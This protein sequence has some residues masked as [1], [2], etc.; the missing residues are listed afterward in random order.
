MIMIDEMLREWAR[1]PTS[2]FPKPLLVTSN[3]WFTLKHESLLTISAHCAVGRWFWWR[4]YIRTIERKTK[5]ECRKI[6]L[7]LI[8]FESSGQNI[9]AAE[10][11]TK[12]AWHSVIL[13]PSLML[14]LQHLGTRSK[15]RRKGPRLWWLLSLS[16]SL[17]AQTVALEKRIT[18][19]KCRRRHR[20]AKKKHAPPD[21]CLDSSF[22]ICGR[23]HKKMRNKCACRLLAG[24]KA[25]KGACNRDCTSTAAHWELSHLLHMYGQI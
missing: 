15:R 8:I 24:C 10:C 25:I 17:L 14:M 9:D 21:S 2:T 19:S 22:A 12:G 18:C 5:E 1:I 6:I 7:K 3:R 20:D 13:H 23:T 16:L 11:D 4:K